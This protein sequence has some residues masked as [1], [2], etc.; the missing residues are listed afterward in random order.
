MLDS[1]TRP[2]ASG[3]DW[4]GWMALL[5]VV[6]ASWAYVAMVIHARSPLVLS[7]LRAWHAGH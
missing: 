5:W 1:S 7:W 3:P 2:H 6:G 4:R